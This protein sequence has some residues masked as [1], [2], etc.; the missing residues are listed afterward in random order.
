MKKIV[1]VVV[2]SCS[3]FL[4]CTSVSRGP[5]D[6]NE[7]SDVSE[8]DTGQ[9]ITCDNAD[10]ILTKYFMDFT[11]PNPLYG[12]DSS[13]ISRFDPNHESTIHCRA[14]L[15]DDFS[16]EADILVQCKADSL[17]QGECEEFRKN[18]IGKNLRNSMFRIRIEMESG[19]SDKS[20]EPEHWSIYLENS[21][22]VMIEPFEIVHSTIKTLADSVYSGYYQI[23]FPRN[24]LKRAITLYFK[25]RTFFGEDLLG[26]DNQFIVLVMSRKKRIVARV[27]WEVS[28][29]KKR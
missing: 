24:L 2:T 10:S 8:M 20:M 3:I 12:D 29:E 21:N 28:E 23:N 19:F 25:N 27:A 7:I 1:L 14:V 17:D 16:T 11:V 5:R 6:V 4:S 18:Y 15:L 26:G 13:R 22:G 9:K